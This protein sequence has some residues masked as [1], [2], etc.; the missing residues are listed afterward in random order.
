MTTAERWESEQLH[1]FRQEFL[2]RPELAERVLATLGEPAPEPER[3][4]VRVKRED[5]DRGICRC[6]A[7][8]A[9]GIMARVDLTEE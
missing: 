3:V 8:S 4:T 2:T 6:L 5:V 7:L 1:R 9:H